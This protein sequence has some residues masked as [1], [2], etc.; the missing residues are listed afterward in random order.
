MSK[1]ADVVPVSPGTT[2]AG[3]PEMF[4]VLDANPFFDGVR[5]LPAGAVLAGT[6]TGRDGRTWNRWTGSV[7]YQ[8]S[9]SAGNTTTLPANVN[10]FLDGDGFARAFTIRGLPSL[11]DPQNDGTTEQP[12]ILVINDSGRR[13]EENDFLTAFGQNGYA[14]GVD[15]DSYTAN[16]PSSSV[17]DGIGSS[18]VHGANAGQLV[19][20]NTIFYM[21]GNLTNGLSDGVLAGD[22]GNDLDVLSQWHTQAGD[23]YAVYFGDEF[24]SRL[25][26]IGG[27]G[28]TYLQSLLA[29][30][31]NDNNVRDEIGNQTAPQV[32][33]TGNVPAFASDFVAFGGCLGIN[34]FD[35][36]EPL[37]GA[38]AA[39]EFLGPG[40]VSGAYSAAASVWH[41]RTQ[42]IGGITY[43][44][45]DATFPYGIQYIFPV[46]AKAPSGASA[47]SLLFEE[48]LLAFNHP[49]NDG[50]ATGA[51]APRLK[52]ALH[53]N[54]PNP[55]NPSTTIA[56]RSWTVS[57]SPESRRS[58]GTVGTAPA[59]PWPAESI[60]TLSRVRAS[61]R[62]ARWRW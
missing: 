28:L 17:T 31:V 45:V 2:L 20:Y 37:A 49:I 26:S 27:A 43:D 15:Y 18:G 14:E 23:R 35:S 24:A 61:P 29:I 11:L 56:F 40:G 38:A 50:G 51:P 4:W 25:Q 5:V 53:E 7:I 58:S 3:P 57:R 54:T 36:I 47:I 8:S 34:T 22:K 13:G 55:F 6:F 32:A 1:L 62:R 59:P 39:H 33:P 10:G 60:S 41:A 16:A 12:E 30:D 48:I 52:A 9:D 21:T 46:Q 19:D 44:R 42:T